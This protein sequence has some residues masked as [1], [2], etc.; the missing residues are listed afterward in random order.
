[1]APNTYK[2]LVKYCHPRQVKTFEKVDEENGGRAQW[3]FQVSLFKDFKFETKELINSCFEFDWDHMKKPRFKNPD[4]VDMVKENLRKI[5]PFTRRVY[6]RLSAT[7]ITGTTFAVG[8][9]TFRDFMS[10]TL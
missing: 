6:K 3:N 5:Y 1:M 10:D 8:W 7:G 2:V 9:N 4:N